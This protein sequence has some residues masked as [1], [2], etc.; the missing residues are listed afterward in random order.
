MVQP[1]LKTCLGVG[2]TPAPL[3]LFIIVCLDYVKAS[4]TLINWI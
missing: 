4:T 2:D 3:I 1:A